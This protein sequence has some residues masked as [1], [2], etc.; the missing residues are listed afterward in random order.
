MYYNSY[1]NSFLLKSARTMG[2]LTRNMYNTLLF[3][4]TFIDFIVLNNWVTH[5]LSLL[6]LR[7]RKICLP[8]AFSLIY[9]LINHFLPM[10]F[11]RDMGIFIIMLV[12]MVIVEHIP[13][14]TS[15]KVSSYNHTKTYLAD[16]IMLAEI[17]AICG[18]IANAVILLSWNLFTDLEDAVLFSNNTVYLVSLIFHLVFIC[19]CLYLIN[20]FVT[21]RC[22]HYSYCLILFA[23]MLC[24]ELL[25]T[26]NQKLPS[27]PQYI[28]IF[29]YLCTIFLSITS[30]FFII[31]FGKN[32]AL[33]K[34]NA[35]HE[36]RL[37]ILSESAQNYNNMLSVSEKIRRWQHDQ[38]NHYLI[39]N[40]MIQN[41]NS[42]E[43]LKYINNLESSLDA[44]VINSINT[45]N[46]VIDAVLSQ[47]M[48]LIHDSQ[49][50]FDY[51]VFIPD[52]LNI[53]QATFSSILCNI[54]D[55]AVEASLKLP[56]EKRKITFSIK[57]HGQ[58][59]LIELSNNSDGHYS[60]QNG[61]LQSSKNSRHGLGL[62][63]LREL[64]DENN[65]FCTFIPEPDKFTVKIALPAFREEI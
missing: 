16:K 26:L 30:I 13:V 53:A 22:E 62:K 59:I 8:I 34:K 51:S 61:A 7:L 65:G 17:F 31:F 10:Y 25:L 24:I 40:N 47:K 11:Y 63:I 19:V 12:Y 64:V 43:A 57:P 21:S 2:E 52:G 9:V 28:K 41:G 18:I 39:I 44:G 32:E 37:Y 48:Q 6:T 27:Y 29:L 33:L 3:L 1:I 45:E 56:I 55:N 36:T 46:P 5:E 35:E 50:N 20:L 15:E 60:Y 54:F 14:S 58:M 49:I 38:K 4:I 42:Q 23:N